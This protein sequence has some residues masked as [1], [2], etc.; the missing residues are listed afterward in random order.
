MMVTLT[1][2]DKQVQAEQG[3][4]V[5]E[6]ARKTGIAIPTLCFYEAVKPYGGCRLCLVEVT[7]GNRTQ[8]AASCTYPVSEGLKVV[9]DSPEVLSA[10]RLVIDLLLSRCPDVPQLRQM[11]LEMGVEK[12][13]FS[14]GKDDCILCGKCV[15]VCHELQGAGAIGMVGRGVKR[16]VM[17]PFGETSQTCRTCGACAFVCPTGHIKN[18]GEISGKTPRPKLSEFNAGLNTRGNIY[19]MYPQAM[20]STPSID[21]ENCIKFLTGDCGACAQFCPAK[22]IDYEQKDE[23]VSLKVGSVIMAPG[24]QP[25]DPSAYGTYG[26][27]RFPN[28]VTSVEFE[29]ILSAS[30]PY[31]G[32]LVRPSDHK[33]PQKIAWLQCVGSRDVNRCDHSYC[34]AVCCMYAIKEAVIAKEHSDKP[35]DTAIFYMDMRTYGKDFEKYYN[36]AKEERGV[37]FQRSRIHTVDQMENGNLLLHY[38][39]ESGEFR[40]E[41]FDMLVLSVGLAPLESAAEL[42]GQLDI[43]LDEHRYAKTDSFAPVSTS[44]DGIYV[45]GVFQGPKDIPQ[46]V[47]EASASAAA[48][49]EHLAEA[50]GSLVRTKE[51]PP[52]LDVSGEKPRIGVFVCNCGINIGGVADVPAVREYAKTLPYV[53][54]VEDNLFTCSQDT[55]ARMKQVILENKIN[56]VVVASCSPRTHE[57]LFQ[58]TIREV[59]LNKYL[60]EMANIRDQNTWVHM[61]NPAKATEKAKDLVRMAVAKAALVEPLQQVALNVN[62]S[63]LVVG[64]GLAGLRT[65]LGVAQQGYHTYLVEKTANLGGVA[66]RLRATWR[67]EPVGTY[68]QELIS[69]VTANPLIEVFTETQVTATAGVIG[70]FTTTLSP[71]NGKGRARTLEHG[72]T[73]LATGGAPYTPTEYLYGKHAGVLTHLELDEALTKGDGRVKDAKSAV[74]I[75]CVGSRIPERPYCSKVCCTHSLESA[76]TLKKRNPEMQVIILFRDIR[77]YGFREDLYRE[78]RKNGVIFVRYEL[79]QLPE[80]T[81]GQDGKLSLKVNDHV[82]GRPLQITPD[83]VVLATAIVPNDNRKLFELFK[84]PTNAEGFLI[85]AHAKL[86]PVDFASEGIFM[87]GLAH[88]PKPVDETI[89]QAMAAVSRTLTVVSKEQLHVGGVAAAVNPDRCAACLTCVRTCPY[90]APRVGE[91]GVAVIDPSACRGCGACAA[92]CPGK[93]IALK[94]FTDEQLLAKEGALFRASSS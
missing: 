36:R 85:E 86:R 35:V 59:G 45:C 52:E 48:S 21:R 5:L 16:K 41:E 89:T 2:N 64:G 65:A 51:L 24:F 37:R 58:E 53:V 40:E 1:I 22:A 83:L 76:I 57:P 32:H 39:T 26:Y 70:N 23:K 72:A 55:Q 18:I 31:Q 84:V 56:R 90:G 34:S 63:V 30:G 43:K 27:K 92:E 12:P 54:H 71:A 82:L 29:R 9:T 25:F 60:F 88:Y 77:S 78:A 94:H 75:Q 44:R 38:A 67:G 33:E 69:K 74:F 17:T 68:L 80:L 8:L 14:G 28:V 10:R 3:T 15:A 79:E 66:L 73:I 7:Q 91:E 81:A 87:A 19:R 20:P 42:A 93:A 47:M 46:S 11:A 4:T 49:T 61:N 13:S 62:K 6:A 50:R